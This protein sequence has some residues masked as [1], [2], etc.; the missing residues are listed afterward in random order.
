MLFQACQKTLPPGY[1]AEARHVYD[2]PKVKCAV[3]EH[4]A[5]QTVCSCLHVHTVEFPVWVTATVQQGPRVQAAMVHLNQNHAV[6]L[7]RK[8]VLME[9]FCDLPV[10]QATVVK[11][12]LA[13]EKILQP[14]V[15]DIGKP[16]SVQPCCMPTKQG[17]G[18]TRSS[19]GYTCWPQIH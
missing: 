10:S 2:L 1:V 4:H 13:G 11:A 3:N 8:A 9:N 5:M 12:A 18:L 7:Q 16:L 15:S 19:I 14:T 17:Y 6:P